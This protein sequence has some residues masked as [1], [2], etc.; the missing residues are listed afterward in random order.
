LNPAAPY[1]AKNGLMD[2]IS[3]FLL[4]RGMTAEIFFG[5]GKAGRMTGLGGA[6]KAAPIGTIGS[7][8][9]GG[10]S[11]GLVD[12]FT[13]I[14]AAGMAV[15]V[16]TASSEVLQLLPGMDAT[17]AQSIIDTRAG[18]DHQDGTE[19]DIPYLQRNEII[20]APGM[21][22]ELMQAMTPFLVTQSSIFLIR[23]EASLGDY[24]RRYEAL[25][26]RR[27]ATDVTILYFRA[28]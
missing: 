3:E 20:N 10:S 19:D 1:V 4:V 8:G 14:S 12:L 28:L 27:N 6:P 15:N 16:N 7:G 13:T 24:M 26:Q 11:V 18:P 5:A 17:L 22:P 25:V 9:T 23:V 21:T 2:D